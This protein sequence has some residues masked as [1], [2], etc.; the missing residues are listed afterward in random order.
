MSM[1]LRIAV[2]AACLSA[3]GLSSSASFGED[4][5][6]A[7]IYGR[8]VHA[9]FGGRYEEA[10]AELTDAI[11][12]GSKDPRCFYYRGLVL[13]SLG[14]NEEANSDFAMGAKEEV[15]DVALSALSSRSLARVQGSTR[16]LIEKARQTARKEHRAE[17][18][19][20]EKLRYEEWQSNEKR[21]LRTPPAEE[22]KP[23]EPTK[24]EAPK[25]EEV[26]PETPAKPEEP[27]TETPPAK[28]A[29]DP[30]G[31]APAAEKPATPAPA[32]PPPAKDPF[33]G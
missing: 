1:R 23:A 4:A 2:L 30:F 17:Q 26:K 20:T 14:R 3:V 10:E 28:P 9:Y 25:P 24:P 18:V 21:M 15:K 12:Q 7:E 33:G 11:M 32:T 27:K 19:K 16:M 8:G 22:V 31:G 29:E 5:V 13:F 6:L